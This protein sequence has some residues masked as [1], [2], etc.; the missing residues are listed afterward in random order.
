VHVLPSITGPRNVL[1]IHWAF[2]PTTGGVESHLA[3]LARLSAARGWRVLVLT[4][5]EEPVR[6]HAYEI[7]STPLLNLDY[8]RSGNMLASDHV[9]ALETL[10]GQLIRSRS[11]HVVHGHNL[12]HFS[13][14]PALALEALRHK[15]PVRVH[16]TFH[17]TWPDILGRDAV[18]RNWDSN[19]AISRYVQ[20]QCEELIGFRPDVLHPGIDTER[21]Y[22]SRPCFC[23]SSVPTILHPARLLPWKGVHVSIQ[24]LR[25]LLDMGLQ[26]KLLLTDTQRI[27]D[28]DRQLTDYRERVLQLVSKF[29]L[30]DH[31]EFVRAAFADMPALYNRADIVLYP[32]TEGE[33]YGLVPPEAMSCARPVVASH[34]GGIVET[35][36][37]GV[38]GFLVEPGNANALANR[39]AHLLKE[40]LLAKQLGDAGRR[41]VE[42]HLSA[43]GYLSALLE[44]Y[45]ANAAAS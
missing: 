9:G 25:L 37:D 34:C 4:G 18:Y 23:G 43:E 33:P 44:R 7:V 10:L 41:H 28:W 35:V 13:S 16:H 12:H 29:Q 21:F 5:E 6:D 32:T 14:A 26:A 45:G 30:G 3:D 17:E 1:H 11:I 42:R 38:T 15:L 24:M 2:P 40:P 31:V 19:Y 20:T 8:I 27:A 39:V 36:M 22:P